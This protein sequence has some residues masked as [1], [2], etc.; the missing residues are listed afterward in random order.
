MHISGLHPVTQVE[1]EAMKKDTLMSPEH[2][3]LLPFNKLYLD[4]CQTFG[5]AGPSVCSNEV[6]IWPQVLFSDIEIKGILTT[7]PVWEDTEA[8][9]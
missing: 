6:F 8:F 5:F 4:K 9:L 3:W 7:Q 1:A 2:L